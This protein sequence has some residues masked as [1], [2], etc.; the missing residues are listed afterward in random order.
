MLRGDER[1]I[2]SLLALIAFGCSSKGDDDDAASGAG[3]GGVPGTMMQTGAGGAMPAGGTGGTPAMPTGSGGMSVP[4]GSGGASA[5]NQPSSSDDDAGSGDAAMPHDAGTSGD[6]TPATGTFP[7]VDDLGGDGPFTAMTEQNTGPGGAFTL[8]RP[9]EL[10]PEGV[11]N[12]VMSWG[13]GALTSPA[14]YDYLLP[15]LATH[16]FVVIAPNTTMV[17][18]TDLKDGLDWLADQ[19]DDSSSP[20]YK[21]LDMNNAAGVGYSLGGL[22]TYQNA[23]DSRYVAYVIISGANMDDSGRSMYIP[24]LHGPVAYLCTED[25]ASRGNC[26]GDFAVVTVP[27]VFGVLKGSVHTSV[28]ELL[29]LG[30]PAIEARLATAVT[31][32]LRWQLMADSTRKAMFIGDDCGLCKDSNWTVQPPKNW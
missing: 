5:P 9:S 20:L 3:S 25:D 26:E 6:H 24:K 32:W 29:N 8:F 2:L 12:P 27:A 4:S 23:D 19:N 14:D 17:A 30:D 7:A 18:G 11:L 1:V 16:G 21:K 13:N 28:T 10:A 22:A 31:G 15:H